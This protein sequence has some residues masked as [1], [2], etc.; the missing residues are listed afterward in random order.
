MS[1]RKRIIKYL[2][3]SFV[4][5][6]SLLMGVIYI[7]SYM[8]EQTAKE[9]SSQLEEM[10]SQIR[11]NMD[12]GLEMHW[13]LVTGLKA[14]AEGKHY[15]DEKELIEAI[16]M[17][18]KGFCTELYGCHVMLLG[19]IGTAHMIEGDVGIWDDI[20]R[21]ADGEECHTFISDTS[22]VDGTFL[23]F[24]QKLEKPITIGENEN[25]FTHLVLLKSVETLK[26]YYTTESYGGNAATYIIKKNGILAYYDAD[27]N[28]YV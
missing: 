2:L 9:R 18:E 23:A 6:A 1:E 11:A 22:N 19:S 17:L 13:N 5:V 26:K 10:I 8:I 20:G 15:N 27:D 3:F 12:I 25:R 28:G 14:T 21:L 16:G 24:T 7:R 4:V